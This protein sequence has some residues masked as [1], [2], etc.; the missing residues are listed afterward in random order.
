M[1]WELKKL[2]K[3]KELKKLKKLKKLKDDS[4]GIPQTASQSIVL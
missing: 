4:S 2:K 3:L 1:E